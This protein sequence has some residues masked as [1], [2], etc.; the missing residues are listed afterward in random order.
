MFCSFLFSQAN[1]YP[2]YV[3]LFKHDTEVEVTVQHMLLA[4]Q[5]NI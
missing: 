2:S 1:L 4:I 5:R 3:N